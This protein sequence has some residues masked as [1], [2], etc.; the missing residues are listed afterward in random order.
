MVLNYR[1]WT[2]RVTAASLLVS[3]AGGACAQAVVD[4]GAPVA[5]TVVI[6]ASA[7]A[8]PTGLTTP[9]A[10]GQVARGARVGVLGDQDMMDTPFS[11]TSFTSELIQDR[12]ARSV[13]D[14]LQLDPAV[15][16]ARGFGNFQE[17]YFIRGFVLSSD[18]VAYN[19][20]YSLL[21]RQYIAADLFDR[22]EV[23]HGAS[24]FLVGASP[25]GDA[26]GGSINL[27]PKRAPDTALTEVTLGAAS[28]G[29]TD[30]STDIARR[31]GPDGSTGVR[32]AA[33]RRS[34]GT[35][36]DDENIDTT[37]FMLGTD[38]RSRDLRIS[39]D[40]GHQDNRL[41]RTRTNVTLAATATAIP[42]APSAS[43]NWAQPWSYSN[44]RDTFGTLRAEADLGPDVTAWVAAGARRSDEANSLADLTV[45]DSAS[46]DAATYRFDNTRRDAV[47]TGD[48]GLRGK[49]QTGSVSHTLILSVAAFRLDKKNA[50]ATSARNALSTNLYQPVD[51]TRPDLSTFG[52][53]LDDPKTTAV[54]KLT[55][56]AMAD[57]L[58][59]MD[60]TALLT[61]G[62]R[63][64]RFDIRNYAYNTGVEGKPYEA[65]RTSPVLGAVLKVDTRVS[66]YANYI[67]SLAQGDSA[68]TTAAN[69]GTQLAP[70]VSRQ[71]EIGVKVDTGKL[72]GSM[73]LF[74]TTRPRA[75]LDA[76]NTF[77]QVGEDRHQG[78]E[79]AVFGQATPL[80]RLVGGLTL[81]DARQHGTG[82]TAT[83]GKR[84][85]GVPD[86][87]GN[88]DV[89]WDLP[90]L[91]GLSADARLVATGKVYA[92]AA[93]TLA[94]PAWTR[95]DA[96][97]RFATQLA[98]RQLALR[99]RIDNLAGRRFWAS[100][101]GSPGSGY[102]VLGNP[103]TFTA[104]ATVDF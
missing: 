75:A 29:Q 2:R 78:A 54:I 63:R 98:G 85:I 51:D 44:E 40:I 19:G 94:V 82:S 15:R 31:F 69:F 26:I 55:S 4:E 48:A 91:K 43:D 84:V 81:L 32:I 96:G 22:V 12:Q 36:I 65:S 53:T 64:Q 68:P 1:P 25:G 16:V 33:S 21:P 30:V 90:F 23:L 76:D 74:T 102:L 86:A 66:L 3:G 61:V 49:A 14:V 83:D 100:S 73:A 13:G 71:E 41:K 97:A 42:A 79:L 103:R 56:V 11:I 67:E 20:L 38:W 18:D 50:F 34:G 6:R 70:Y 10:G 58:S 59:F 7:D 39:A 9:Y 45:N 72:A 17:S 104:S 99:A 60:D 57:T 92:D 28:G 35:G 62:A 93:N 24:A 95:I 89:D 77:V 27:L 8:S 52:N 87:Q 80:L 88:I 46:G 5:Q 101:G 37:V 47:D